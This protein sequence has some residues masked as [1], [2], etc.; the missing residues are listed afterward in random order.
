M[1]LSR[2]EDWSGFP[3]PTPGDLPDPRTEPVSPVSPA[4][5]VDSLPAKP[6]GSLYTYTHTQTHTHTYIYIRIYHIF[7]IT[8]KCY[9]LLIVKC[10]R[11][12]FDKN[13]YVCVVTVPV[14]LT[15]NFSLRFIFSLHIMQFLQK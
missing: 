9:S 1:G 10:Q 13:T 15:R 3:R 12:I 8:S 7:P 4:L 6:S 2:Q 14:P 5:Q 11:R